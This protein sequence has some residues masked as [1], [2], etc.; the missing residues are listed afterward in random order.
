M[1]K[2]SRLRELQNAL[3]VLEHAF[4]NIKLEKEIKLT[5]E[6]NEFGISLKLGD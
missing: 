6:K 1:K 4:G 5:I 3:A 2:C